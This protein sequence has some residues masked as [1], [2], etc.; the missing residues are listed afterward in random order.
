METLLDLQEIAWRLSTAE[1]VE[2]RRALYALL[3]ST[4]TGIDSE[5]ELDVVAA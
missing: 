5:V 2:E 1:S 4:E 3:E